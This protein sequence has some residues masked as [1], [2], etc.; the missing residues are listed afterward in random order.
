[1]HKIK[2]GSELPNQ[3]CTEVQQ[4]TDHVQLQLFFPRNSN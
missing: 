1:M 4:T 2:A 3:M